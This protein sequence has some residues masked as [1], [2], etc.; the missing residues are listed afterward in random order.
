[1]GISLVDST[2]ASMNKNTYRTE[3]LST[4]DRDVSLVL[5]SSQLKLGAI[6]PS[7]TS[8]VLVVVGQGVDTVMP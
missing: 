3:L 1:V 7:N 2:T 4:V 6:D 5:T 8:S